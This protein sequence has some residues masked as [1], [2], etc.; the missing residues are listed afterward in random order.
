METDVG[1][2]SAR[3]ALAAARLAELQARGEEAVA[4]YEKV[5]REWGA[6]PELVL[7]AAVLRASALEV[8]SRDD[9]AHGVWESV[10]RRFEILDSAHATV[11]APVVSAGLRVAE[12]WNERRRIPVRDSTL[13]SEEKRYRQALERVPDGPAATGLLDAIAEAR[14]MRGDLDG[15]LGAAREALFRIGP[16]ADSAKARRVQAIAERLFEAGRWDSARAYARWNQTAFHR[17]LRLPALELEARAWT[18]ARRPD[19]ALATY[20]RILDEYGSRPDADAEARFQR[21]LLLEAIDQWTLA[22]SEFSALYAAHPSHP[23]ALESWAQVVAHH[24]RAGE[25]ELARI[26]ADHA[27]AAID[28]WID[29]QHDESERGRAR[30][31]RIR[32]QL[33]AGNTREAITDLQT[34]WNAVGLTPASAR[35][36]ERAA[37]AADRELR[38]AALARNLWQILSGRAPDMGL[39]R[40]AAKALARQAP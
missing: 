40:R 29:I 16:D 28:Q 5:E 38:D 32:V 33:E 2:I 19:S 25:M 17:L 24:R 35:L 27:L 8:L 23:R 13:R 37:E 4:G 6:L 22:R 36:G 26:E 3:A 1:E 31:A 7:E 30:E 21:A 10:S 9:E 18:R 20:D 39:R 14:S 11:R 15:A 12:G 34:L